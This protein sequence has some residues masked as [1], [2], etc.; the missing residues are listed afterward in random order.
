MWVAVM[1]LKVEQGKGEQ[2]NQEKKKICKG[3]SKC[4]RNRWRVCAF[5]LL[6]QTKPLRFGLVGDLMC[7]VEREVNLIS[8][9]TQLHAS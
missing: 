4:P 1:D 5:P 6:H 3:S 8:T 7:K 2:I 9:A